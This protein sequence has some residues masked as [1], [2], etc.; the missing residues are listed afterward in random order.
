MKII[1][2]IY[3]PSKSLYNKLNNLYQKNYKI[4]FL[5]EIIRNNVLNESDLWSSIN[6]D[7][8]SGK[9]IKDRDVCNLILEQIS[10]NIDE[11]YILLGFPKTPQQ[12]KNLEDFLEVKRIDYKLIG[13]FNE[14]ENDIILKESYREK[15]KIVEISNLDDL[16]SLLI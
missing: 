5:P 2:I 16:S 1:S 12:L 4:I 10:K 11:N 3:P 13:V 15:N 6:K 7:I 9:P 8:L 14:L